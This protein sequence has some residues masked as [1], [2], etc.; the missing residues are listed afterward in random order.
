V[1]HIR[2][3]TNQDLL[4]LEGWREGRVSGSPSLFFSSAL[5]ASLE[6]SDTKVYEPCILGFADCSQVDMLG[7]RYTSVNFGAEKSLGS[8]NW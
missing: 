7:V 6:L 8:P 4:P 1:L 2:G 3:T 5:L